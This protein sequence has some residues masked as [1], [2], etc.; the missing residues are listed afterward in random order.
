MKNGPKTLL[1]VAAST[2]GLLS[3]STSADTPSTSE[4]RT[5]SWRS[6]VHV[7]PVRVRNWMADIHSSCVILLP[8]GCAIYIRQ[9]CFQKLGVSRQDRVGGKG[10]KASNR[11]PIV[12]T[13]RVSLTNSW[14]LVT[15]F[16]KMN[17]TRLLR[18]QQRP[19]VIY[20]IRTGRA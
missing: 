20:T 1:S 16:W 15:R 14:S 10:D 11:G 6:G 2:G 8:K 3:A 13:Y 9:G 19:Y 12:G 5:N 18:S 7:C 4:S 17:L